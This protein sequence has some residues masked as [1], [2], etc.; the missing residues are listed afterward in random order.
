MSMSTSMPMRSS[1]AM[2]EADAAVS[3]KPTHSAVEA[4]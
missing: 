1:V 4:G 2:A 3:S